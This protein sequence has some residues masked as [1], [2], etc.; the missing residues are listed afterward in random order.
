M[1]SGW[2]MSRRI[3]LSWSFS[4][5]WGDKC[6][7]LIGLKPERKRT[8]V[9]PGWASGL[10]P[11]VV[12]KCFFFW[13]GAPINGVLD[14]ICGSKN[15]P[16]PMLWESQNLQIDICSC[17]KSNPD[18]P[19]CSLSLCSVILSRYLEQRQAS[20]EHNE[21]SRKDTKFRSCCTREQLRCVSSQRSWIS[22]YLLL[23]GESIAF[24][25]GLQHKASSRR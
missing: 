14:V 5:Q 9:R 8:R 4:K 16:Y 21:L 17:Q 15:P 22:I 12:Q 7:Q 19:D 24:L 6:L 25:F 3:A 2:S 13:D 11:H 1:K 18:R 20:C 10:V 23:C